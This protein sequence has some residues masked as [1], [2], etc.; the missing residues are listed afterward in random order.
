MCFA[1]LGW[2]FLGMGFENMKARP[3]AKAKPSWAGLCSGQ[4]FWRGGH[5]FL[6]KPD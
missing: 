6:P 3:R 1:G 5:W 4:G 2:A